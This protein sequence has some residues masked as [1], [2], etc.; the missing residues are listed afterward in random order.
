MKNFVPIHKKTKKEQKEY[1]SQYR[2]TWNGLNPV[3]R[4]VPNGKGYN[5][6]KLKN[7]D[8]RKGRFSYEKDNLLIFLP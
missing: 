2:N 8:R 1:Y 4:T 3:T 6:K 7:E 5:R